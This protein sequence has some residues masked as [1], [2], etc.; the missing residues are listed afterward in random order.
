MKD[1]IRM[2]QLAGIITEGQA[3]KM[4]EVLDEEIT[5][6]M[7]EDF[8]VGDKV[9]INKNITRF[10]REAHDFEVGDEAEIT[11]IDDK[12]QRAKITPSNFSIALKALDLI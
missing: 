9:R 1:L 4:M 12:K 11:A 6:G 3:K 2:N 5:E 8:K 10:D 7:N